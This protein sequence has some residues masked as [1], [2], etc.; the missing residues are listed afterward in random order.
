MSF[1]H[2]YAVGK[3]GCRFSLLLLHGTGG[4]ESSMIGLGRKIAPEASLLGVRGKVQE[5]GMNR[6]FRRFP[7]GSFDHADLVFRTNELAD[8][9]ESAR[10]DYDL[11]DVIAV[12]YSNG[13]NIAA[14][15]LLLRPRTLAGAV[16]FRATVPIVP[17]ELPNLSSKK[18]LV[19]SG[20]YDEL[21]PIESAKTLISMLRDA[22]AEVTVRWLDA[23][24]GLMRRDVE[25]SKEWLAEKFG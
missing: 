17:K 9:V 2:R 16:L 13:A 1:V 20:R 12:G 11:R 6:F 24:H 15:M 23:G 19:S 14:S 25:G 7:D 4:D 5:N 18:I 22:G 21:V 8:F 10:K 3:R